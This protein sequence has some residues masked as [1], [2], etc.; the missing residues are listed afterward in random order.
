MPRWRLCDLGGQNK[1]T[2]SELGAGFILRSNGPFVERKKALNGRKLKLIEQNKA[3]RL[4]PLISFVPWLNSG[5]ETAMG[6]FTCQL[7][8]I[9]HWGRQINEQ[10][11]F[12]PDIPHTQPV[13]RKQKWVVLGQAKTQREEWKLSCYLCRFLP[14]VIKLRVSRLRIWVA[15]I[16]IVAGI[17]VLRKHRQ[18]VKSQMQKQPFLSLV[19]SNIKKSA[20]HKTSKSVHTDS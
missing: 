1:F 6:L 17:R 12:N 13:L 18:V 3:H 10:V 20:T 2:N 5:W 8:A 16:H 14:V 7:S 15:I 19:H 11:Q 9:K 4:W